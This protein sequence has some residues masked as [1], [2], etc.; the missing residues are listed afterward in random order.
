VIEAYTKKYWL[1]ELK[2]SAGFLESL[3]RTTVWDSELEFKTEKAIFLGF[4]AIRKLRESKLLSSVVCGLN[5]SLISHPIRD[6][7]VLNKDEH[8]SKKYNVGQN[9]EKNLP[10][11]TL[12]DQFVHSK[13]YSPFI[14]EGL[15]CLGFF[16][17]SDSE[18]KNQVYYVQLIKV[19]SIF[20]SVVHDNKIQLKLDV[21]G[22]V[23]TAKNIKEHT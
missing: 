21:N 8:W 9:D 5:T 7:V 23:I 2:D 3:Y 1:S 19:V 15:G 4:Y 6:G 14:P 18:C 10:L 17:A 11:K 13:I 22:A 12:C 20:L 16:F